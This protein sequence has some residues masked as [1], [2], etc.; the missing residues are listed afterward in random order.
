M[1][2]YILLKDR[3]LFIIPTKEWLSASVFEL[4]IISKINAIIEKLHGDSFY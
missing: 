2:R 3:Y 4:I 1:R